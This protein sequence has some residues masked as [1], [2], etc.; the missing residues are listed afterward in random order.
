MLGITEPFGVAGF[1][2]CP[3]DAADIVGENIVAGIEG[4]E[5]GRLGGTNSDGGIAT[6][7]V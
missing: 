6:R 2:I 1:S 4:A 5:P 7:G 3:G